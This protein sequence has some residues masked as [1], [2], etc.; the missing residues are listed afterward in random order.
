MALCN[1]RVQC[2]DEVLGR[3]KDRP[4][5]RRRD[6]AFDHRGVAQANRTPWADAGIC[7]RLASEEA[8][9]GFLSVRQEAYEIGV[10]IPL[11]HDPRLEALCAIVRSPEY[12]RLLADLPGYDTGKTGE[13]RSIGTRSKAAQPTGLPPGH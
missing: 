12:R 13:P 6:H 2:L 9:L 4:A 3:A 11:N 7:P 8:G 10:S 1:S 5:L